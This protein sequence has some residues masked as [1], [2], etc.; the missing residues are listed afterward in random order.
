MAAGIGAVAAGDLA[1]DDRGPQRSFRLLEN[2]ADRRVPARSLSA[3]RASSSA[4]RRLRSLFLRPSRSQSEHV[5]ARS[6]PPA[7]RT[8]ARPAAP[9][10]PEIQGFFGDRG[11]YRDTFE[12]CA[13]L[14]QFFER[15]ISRATVPICSSTAFIGTND[16]GASSF[17]AIHVGIEAALPAAA[18]DIERPGGGR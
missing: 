7:H 10:F 12:L 6:M 15:P 9:V 17:R 3:V 13:S 1:V 18:T 14:F 16:V 11:V 5:E 8:P 4:R 2:G